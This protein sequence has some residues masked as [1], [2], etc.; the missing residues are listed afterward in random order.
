MINIIYARFHKETTWL[1][2]LAHCALGSL[3][4]FS[5][6]WRFC[7]FSCYCSPIRGES[8]TAGRVPLP[9]TSLLASA[10]HIAIKK[11]SRLLN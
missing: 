3:F 6:R 8:T 9:P 11:R 5:R 2:A 10:P 4:N 1:A 7:C